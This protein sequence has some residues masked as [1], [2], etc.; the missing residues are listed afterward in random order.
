MKPLALRARER[1]RDCFQYVIFFF[2]PFSH[3][4]KFLKI[5]KKKKKR[6]QDFDVGTSFKWL[7]FVCKL[8]WILTIKAVR[9]IQ[10]RER[11]RG[12]IFLGS[13][14][15]HVCVW[16]VNVINM[17]RFPR[18]RKYEKEMHR[19]RERKREREIFATI[20]SFTRLFWS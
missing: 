7:L 20:H 14:L 12:A 18:D 5:K 8:C 15:L 3:A 13:M 17:S 9:I 10:E 16:R 4:C 19:Q 2:L 6:C 1:E 11:E